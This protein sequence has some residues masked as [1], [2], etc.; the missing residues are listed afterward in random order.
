MRLKSLFI[1]AVFLTFGG[2]AFGYFHV[3]NEENEGKPKMEEFKVLNDFSKPSLKCQIAA[4]ITN[5]VAKKLKKD[6]QLQCIGTGGTMMHEIEALS[7]SFIYYK[8]V[9]VKKARALLVTAVKEYLAAINTSE[10]IRPYLKNY[11]FTVKNVKVTIS[12]LH[13]DGST[14]DAGKILLFASNRDNL[15]FYLQEP[16][17][18]RHPPFYAETYEKSLRIVEEEKSQARA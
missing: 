8:E 3:N 4:K 13:P 17:T 11:P 2:V 18:F 12:T 9:D 6:Q 5:Q 16:E 7:M 10:E 1:L 15:E 14:T